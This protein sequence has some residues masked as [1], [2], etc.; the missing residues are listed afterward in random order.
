MLLA[1]PMR[2]TLVANATERPIDTG[3]PITAE[4]AVDTGRPVAATCP[5]VTEGPIAA[6]CRIVAERPITPGCGI[7][8]ERPATST[9]AVRARLAHAVGLLNLHWYAAWRARAGQLGEFRCS[10]PYLGAL[11]YHARALEHRIRR[12]ALTWHDERGHGAVL[13]GTSGTAGAM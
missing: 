6:T 1:L 7:S 9:V 2:R 4:R 13:A 12:L 8:A 10:E 11:G 5:I 3:R